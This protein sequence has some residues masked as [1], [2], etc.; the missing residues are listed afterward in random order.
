MGED[1]GI[2]GETR[3]QSAID[4]IKTLIGAYD[5][6]GD[7]RINLVTFSTVATAQEAWLSVDEVVDIL[8]DLVAAGV[9]NYDSAL[10]AAMENYSQDG[11]LENAQSISYFFSDGSPNY[12]DGDS[13][14]LD[15]L[16]GN[17]VYYS[18]RG[19]SPQEEE[20]WTDFLVENGVKSYAIGLGEG[21]TEDNLNPI[22][23]DGSADEDIDAAIVTSFSDLDDSL[24][25]TV[26]SPVSG[27]LVSGSS[28]DGSLLGADG[29]YLQSVTVDGTT[30]SYDPVTN[31]VSATGSD[32]S[33]YDA[34][35]LELIIST[36]L[37]GSMLFNL[38]SGDF[39][40]TPPDNVSERSTDSFDYVTVDNDGDTNASSVSIDVDKLAVV[41]GTDGNDTLTG[42]GDG[43][44]YA[45]YLVGQGGNDTLSGGEGSD[46]LEG[47]SGN[48]TLRGG[49]GNDI[50]SGGEGDDLLVGGAG[51]DILTG[52][53]GADT[54]QW[55]SGHD[56]NSEGGMATDTIT[57]FSVADGDVIDLS[58]LLQSND[59][60][61]T[62]SSFLHFESDGEGGTNIEISVDGSDGSNITQE[63][64]LQ[65][66]DLTSGGDTDTQIIQS[67]L[68]SNSLKTNV[69]G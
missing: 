52:G 11:A 8:D 41:I 7:V 10:A 64:N 9:T 47:G 58:D 20:I 35:S 48:D 25:A 49:T 59:D 68:D 66:V 34:D 18:D 45:D 63:I 44:F 28:V 2:N 39:T 3:L 69:D 19:I 30:Y 37:G 24:A 1:D 40:Y 62:L 43:P 6:F 67:L 65:D 27:Q 56:I 38:G 21:V 54:F 46:R 53:D 17:T 61:D 5:D 60:A 16:V 31:T 32:N 42:D 50:L 55:L 14:Q 4:S 51:N 26:Q 12:G 15:V 57:D 29:G 22:A 13:S 23:Y 36:D 33:S